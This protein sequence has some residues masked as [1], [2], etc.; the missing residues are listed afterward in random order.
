MNSDL[1]ASVSIVYG[2]RQGW[3]HRVANLPE[4]VAQFSPIPELQRHEQLLQVFPKRSY[5][6]KCGFH[7]QGYEAKK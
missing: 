7:L 1:R 6:A 4:T 2:A 3:W 5:Y